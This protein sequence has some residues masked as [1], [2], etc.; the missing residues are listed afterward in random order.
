MAITFIQE[1]SYK[2]GSNQSIPTDKNVGTYIPVG[3]SYGYYVGAFKFY[4]DT[5]IQ[6]PKI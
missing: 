5:S 4:T 6:A 3:Y 1:W 2:H